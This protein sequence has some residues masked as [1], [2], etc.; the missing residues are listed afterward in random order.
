[1]QENLQ[2]IA[3]KSV[4]IIENILLMNKKSNDK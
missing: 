2:K 3:Y 4:Y 1:M